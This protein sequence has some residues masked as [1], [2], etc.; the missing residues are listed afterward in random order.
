MLLRNANNS[1][2]YNLDVVGNFVIVNINDFSYFESFV[3]RYTVSHYNNFSGFDI[4]FNLFSG[5]NYFIFLDTRSYY[6][7][8]LDLFSDDNKFEILAVC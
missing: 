2:F 5:N 8:L 3:M 7:D 4:L 6:D 1:V